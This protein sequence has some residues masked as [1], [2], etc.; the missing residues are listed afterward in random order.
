MVEILKRTLG[1]KTFLLINQEKNLA[2]ESKI[3]RK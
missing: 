3:L 1:E 2:F